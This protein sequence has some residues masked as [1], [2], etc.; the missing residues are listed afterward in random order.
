MLQNEVLVPHTCFHSLWNHGWRSSSN[1]K[2]AY[3][4]DLSYFLLSQL[5]AVFLPTPCDAEEWGKLMNSYLKNISELLM[6]DDEKNTCYSSHSE[7]LKER[8]SN[9]HPSPE[10]CSG[11]PKAAHTG[12]GRRTWVRGR[13]AVATPTHVRWMNQQAASSASGQ[14]PV[15]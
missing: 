2:A 10:I 15:H 8:D 7:L 9:W 3:S 1:R 5:E 14:V 12:E 4:S 11:F 6:K 13:G